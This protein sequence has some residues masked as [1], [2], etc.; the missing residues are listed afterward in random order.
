ML[1][2][3]AEELYEDAPCGYLT[4][5]PDGTIRRANRTFLQLTGHAADELVGRRFDDLLP[6]GAKIYYETH[7]APLLQMQ[8][9]VHEIALEIVRADGGRLP[10][11]VNAV[12]KHDEEGRPLS[13]RITV[14]DASDRRRY[15]R[16][17]LAARGEA[18]ARAAAATALEHVAEG[19]V[20]LDADGRIT[21]LNPAAERILGVQL[22][23]A[24]GLQ[25]A[26]V[27]PDWTTVEARVPILRREG[28]P[29]PP[30]SC[31]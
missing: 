8:G 19:V 7:Y 4:M 28:Q 15:E 14:F 23:E 12:A 24:R 22:D 10:V 20:L 5:S 11:L 31:R 6:P 25:L 26:A 16:E 1:E 30:S 21:L 17:L 9:R 2:D 18:E 3:T 29:T 27:A 13:V